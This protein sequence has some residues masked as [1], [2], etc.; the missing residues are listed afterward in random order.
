MKGLYD[1]FTKSA[2]LTNNVIQ[3][4]PYYDSN[5]NI[6]GVQSSNNQQGMNRMYRQIDQFFEE[7]SITSEQKNIF[8]TNIEQLQAKILDHDAFI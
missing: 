8:N 7:N 1:V 3:L 6:N 4:K 2:N 5:K